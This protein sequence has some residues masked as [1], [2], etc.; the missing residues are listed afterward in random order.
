[1]KRWLATYFGAGLSPIAPGT[2]SSLAASVT[3]WA[4]LTTFGTNNVQ[5]VWTCE[6]LLLTFG[7]LGT[8]F[9]GPWIPTHFGKKDPGAFV[10]DEVAGIALAT[11]FQPIFPGRRELYVLL[12]TFLAFRL[13]DVWKPW[14][15]KRL[16]QL[17]AGYGVL[18]DDLAAAVY[19]NVL[20]QI[21]LRT[22]F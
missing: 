9:L 21:I 10:L 14:P 3:L 5:V 7:V 12:A 11:L 6:I 17:P 8:I 2:V 16:E 18:M 19:A 15:C 20:C 1:M 22:L 4:L 13:F